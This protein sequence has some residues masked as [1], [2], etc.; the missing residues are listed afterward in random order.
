VKQAAILRQSKSKITGQAES[1]NGKLAAQKALI[2]KQQK[3]I[4]ELERL[5]RQATLELKTVARSPQ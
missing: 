5:L 1:L 4:S 3:Q 2:A